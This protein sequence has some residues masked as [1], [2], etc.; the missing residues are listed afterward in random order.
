MIRS[1]RRCF[2]DIRVVGLAY[3]P[4]ESGIYAADGADAVYQ[5]PCLSAGVDAFLDRIDY[6][7]AR[8]P[9]DMLVPTLDAEI[10][11]LVNARGQLNERGIHTVLPSLE[12]FLARSKD[13]LDE[14]VKGT[15]ARVPKSISVSS[16][17]ALVAASERLR[18]PVMVKGC[19]YDALKA[20]STFS[21][22]KAFIKIMDTWGGPVIVQ[23]F[24]R[25]E[26]FNIAA[27][28]D[29]AGAMEGFCCIRKTVRS[30]KGKGFG[31]I[32]IDD[33][34]LTAIGERIVE[35]LKWN[36]PCELEFV[37]DAVDGSYYLIEVNPR[38]PAWIDFPSTFGYNLPKRVIDRMAGGGTEPLPGR[39]PTGHF[40]LRH[41]T[42]ILGRIEDLGQL[43]VSGELLNCSASASGHQNPTG[44]MP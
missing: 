33:P 7:Q 34:E 24:I 12:S 4:Y 37:Q 14:L 41:T 13:Q 29:G 22:S 5:I 6:I 10:L 20:D 31:G 1:L 11:T 16:A 8:D 18:Y 15:G 32:V 17:D 36:G 35:K 27:V 9:I 28:G 3:G 38:F 30:E 21:L 44:V 42:D 25:G 19:C 39:C 2:N 26:E 40:F 23:E 43:T